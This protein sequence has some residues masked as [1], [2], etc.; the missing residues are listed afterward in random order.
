MGASVSVVG[1]SEKE[2]AEGLGRAT[3]CPGSAD[4]W[5]LT[6]EVASAAAVEEKP[7]G[8]TE[9]PRPGRI[10]ARSVW[11]QQLHGH[12][13]AAASQRRP[14]ELPLTPPAP[15]AIPA[16]A[17]APPEFPAP[18]LGPCPS[19]P[20]LRAPASCSPPSPSS[21]TASVQ[22]GDSPPRSPAPDLPA[23]LRPSPGE[24]HH[25]PPRG[26]VPHPPLR[27]LPFSLR[28]FLPASPLH[29]R[30]GSGEFSGACVSVCVGEVWGG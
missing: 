6:A 22:P 24:K 5:G 21:R 30:P 20:P 15:A 17:R 12:G 27:F 18:N 7:P 29:Q 23:P 1:C 2:L 19:A 4:A 16:E 10:P 8:N 9:T 26:P 11:L 3:S 13:S 25:L 14:G 28:D